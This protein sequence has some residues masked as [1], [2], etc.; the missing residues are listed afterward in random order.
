MPLLLRVCSTH[1]FVEHAT[2]P[3][4]HTANSD[5]AC[6]ISFA[7]LVCICF[8]MST[9]YQAMCYSFGKASKSPGDIFVSICTL[10]VQ[11]SCWFL[12]GIM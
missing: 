1:V 3:L 9:L 4:V 8:D 6:T 7:F 11:S 10:F 5:T 2:L 12:L